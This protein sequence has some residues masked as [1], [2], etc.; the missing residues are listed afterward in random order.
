MSAPNHLPPMTKPKALAITRLDMPVYLAH[1]EVSQ[2]LGVEYA[3]RGL[4][5]IV[6]DFCAQQ[7]IPNYD[8]DAVNA[9]MDMLSARAGKRWAWLRLR[10]QDRE[11]PKKDSHLRRWDEQLCGFTSADVYQRLVPLE[12]LTNA[13]TLSRRFPR[14]NFFVSD[15][16][17]LA[18]DPE[19]DPFIMCT[20]HQGWRVVFGVWDEPGFGQ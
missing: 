9:Y 6:Q 16:A 14:L 1:A 20:S 5:A 8:N 2:Q 12:H 19:P 18:K 13:L 17:V 7:N 3:G 11:N 4:L 10:E 15:Y